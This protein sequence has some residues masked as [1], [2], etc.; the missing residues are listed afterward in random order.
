VGGYPDAASRSGLV[1]AGNECQAGVP[2]YAPMVN[3]MSLAGGAGALPR[4][5]R[6]IGWHSLSRQFFG[7]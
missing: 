5:R 3:K 4:L 1:R 6:E 7:G 2:S